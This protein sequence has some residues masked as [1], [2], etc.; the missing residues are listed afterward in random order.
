MWQA[1]MGAYSW[2]SSRRRKIPC[3][4]VLKSC[5]SSLAER[6]AVTVGVWW[7]QRLRKVDS[8]A[9]VGGG[10]KG[11]ETQDLVKAAARVPMY[12]ALVRESYVDVIIYVKRVA[13]TCRV[14]V[15]QSK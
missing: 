10:R 14:V 4:K 9:G 2:A 11:R 6:R 7:W 15:P 12:K 5:V 8:V 3:M 13:H 1:S